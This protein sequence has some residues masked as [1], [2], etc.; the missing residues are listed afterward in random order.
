MPRFIAC[1]L[2]GF[3]AWSRDLLLALL[4]WYCK[5]LHQTKRS[6]WS[7]CIHEKWL[8]WFNAL[9][10]LHCCFIIHIHMFSLSNFVGK[11]LLKTFLVS[12]TLSILS[13]DN[14]AEYCAVMAL[15]LDFIHY[16]NKKCYVLKTT[17][18]ETDCTY[19]RAGC[20]VGLL[21][22]ANFYL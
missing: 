7:T 14:M 6:T 11:E 22:E 8:P 20:W 19:R 3:M 2:Y 18:F 4:H 12:W 9:F 15:H 5:I 17:A 16:M 13:V 10:S 1:V 21:D